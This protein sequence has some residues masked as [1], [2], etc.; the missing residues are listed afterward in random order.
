MADPIAVEA[1]TR[2]LAHIRSLPQASVSTVALVRNIGEIIHVLRMNPAALTDFAQDLQARAE[3]FYEAV[4]AQP[5]PPELMAR[6]VEREICN[7]MGFPVAKTKMPVVEP[8]RGTTVIQPVG[9]PQLDP[10]TAAAGLIA[11]LVGPQAP[12]AAPP[13]EPPPRIDMSG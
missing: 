9:V 4:H 12:L 13:V 11:E 1:S 2:L 5:A 8:V 3:V 10:S 7:A 6:Q